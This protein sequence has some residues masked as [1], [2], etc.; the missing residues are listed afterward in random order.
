MLIL[1]KLFLVRYNIHHDHIQ[2]RWLC[3][4]MLHIHLMLHLQRKKTGNIITFTQFEE[5]N[6]LSE[7]RNDAESSEESNKDSIIP[8]LLIKEVM[9]AMDS[10][11]E[12]DDDPMSTDMLE[13]IRDGSQYHPDVNRREARY[14]LRERIKHRQP[15]WKGALKSTQNMGKGLHKV[16]KT[17]AKEI[18]QYLPPLG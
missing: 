9:D 13:D 16:F 18:S 6:L 5:G 15:E 2:K 4:Q 17:F 7:T 1:V 8:P 11:D 3:F 14:K 12:S 10:G